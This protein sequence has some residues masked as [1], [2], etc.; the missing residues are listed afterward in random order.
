MD[1]VMRDV[2]IKCFTPNLIVNWLFVKGKKGI[3]VFYLHELHAGLQGVVETEEK[4]EILLHRQQLS[5]LKWKTIK[6]FNILDSGFH[7]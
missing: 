3:E 1:R 4:Q 7:E 2:I 6:I 5:Q